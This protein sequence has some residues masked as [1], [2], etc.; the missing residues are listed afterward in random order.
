V[1]LEGPEAAHGTEAN[2]EAHTVL[3][4]GLRRIAGEV[5]NSIDFHLG[6]E[7]PAAGAAPQVERVLLTGSAVRVSG[8]AELLSQ[9]LSLPVETPDV[10]GVDAD[11][12]GLFAVAAGLAVEE[13]AA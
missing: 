9:R 13:V 8:F 12:R 3:A 4:A 10:D 7:G 6:A 5:R 1:R 11:G 2:V